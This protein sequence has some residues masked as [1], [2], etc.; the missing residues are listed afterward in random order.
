[1][2]LAYGQ[3]KEESEVDYGF[4]LTFPNPIPQCNG[5]KSPFQCITFLSKENRLYSI[6]D[7]TWMAGNILE[8]QVV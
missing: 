4:Q 1:M 7:R 6:F 8:G 2:T 3:G 5:M